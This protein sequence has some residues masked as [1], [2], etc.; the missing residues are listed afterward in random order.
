MSLLLTRGFSLEAGQ[1][2]GLQAWEVQPNTSVFGDILSESGEGGSE[3]CSREGSTL[4]HA[5]K[6]GEDMERQGTLPG[7]NSRSWD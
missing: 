4:H 2:Q 3:E 6:N 1:A 5:F 7:S